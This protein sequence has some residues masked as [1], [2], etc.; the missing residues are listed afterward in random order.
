MEY[1]K[2]IYDKQNGKCFYTDEEL[3]M[4]M[5]H[6]ELGNCISLD[7]II[8]GKGYIHGNVVLC[9]K[10]FN[11]IKNSIT[12]EEMKEWMAPIY[13]RLVDAGYVK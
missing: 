5:S 8:P 13:E 3:G 1:L 4:Q 12:L 11:T 6:G 7:R 2:K 9:T 10:R